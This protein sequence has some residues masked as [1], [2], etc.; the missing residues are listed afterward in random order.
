LTLLAALPLQGILFFGLYIL[1]GMRARTAFVSSLA[2]MTYSE[3]ALI[4]TSAVIKAQ[5]LTEQWKP[6]ISV[7]VAGSLAIAAPLNRASDR[8]FDWVEPLLVRFEKKTGHSD[9]LPESFGN[10]QWLIM[11]MGRT[12]MS[13]YQA[14]SKQ[15]QT[16]IGIDAD[17]IVLENLLD[18]GFKVVYADVSDS[19]LW[20]TLPLEKVKG[21][22]LTLPSFENRIRAIS[23]LRKNG[24]TGIIGTICYLADD[25]RLL[26]NNGAS[27]VIHPLY[28]A[29]LQLANQMLINHSHDDVD[30]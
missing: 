26:T 21:V 20:N 9:S 17:P 3:F 16:V 24:F 4:T 5:L 6:I 23:Q 8:L 15:E 1:A 7:A 27:Y 13:A 28:E 18:T 2:L 12:G 10:P 22:I 14:L 25:E 29:G 30:F 19:E 11:G